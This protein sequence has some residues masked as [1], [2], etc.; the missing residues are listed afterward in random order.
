MEL[1]LD[2]L[3]HQPPALRQGR[4]CDAD[5]AAE[6]GPGLAKDPRVAQAAAPDGD[7]V[8]SGFRQHPH[9]IVGLADAAAANH[10]QTGRLLDPRQHAPVR[11]SHVGLLD[12]SRMHAHGRGA[13][14]FRPLGHFH[15][16]FLTR[17]RA[18]TDLDGHRDGNG[19]DNRGDNLP[20][21]LGR[22]HQ[23]PPFTTGKQAADGTLEIQVDQVEPQFG[24]HP[25]GRGHDVRVGPADLPCA[26]R[27]AGLRIEQTQGPPVAAGDVGRVDP[28]GDHQ[29]R[30]GLLHQQPEGKIGMLLHRGQGQAIGDGDRPDFH[31]VY[32]I[33]GFARREWSESHHQMRSIA[34]KWWD[35]LH[36]AHPTIARVLVIRSLSSIPKLDAAKRR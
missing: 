11:P 20:D 6:Q 9:R 27:L 25:R 4:P 33:E 10:R 5:P 16:R 34:G 31:N 17:V 22:V 12:A 3:Q 18:A 36:S 23:G 24:N 19:M 26:G 15:G 13:G 29:A 7:G 32:S 2:Q 21:P 14:V 30:P 8:D 35:S 28:L 1:A